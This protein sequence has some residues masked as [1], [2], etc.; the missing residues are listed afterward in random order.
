ML[1]LNTTLTLTL[2]LILIRTLPRIQNPITTLPLTLY[3]PR[4]HGR[5]K[6][7]PEQMSDHQNLSIN[8]N[9]ATDLK[10]VLPGDLYPTVTG[11]RLDRGQLRVEELH[12]LDQVPLVLWNRR[13]VRTIAIL[14]TQR[15]ERETEWIQRDVHV[16]INV[17]LI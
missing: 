2:I 3:S 16:E 12:L 9:L 8:Q 5:S 15:T 10:D 4:Y 17:N 14:S 13:R 11:L 1:T 6:L 7:S